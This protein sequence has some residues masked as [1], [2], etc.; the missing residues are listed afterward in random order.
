MFS[1]PGSTEP[2]TELIYFLLSFQLTR[3]KQTEKH[4]EVIALELFGGVYNFRLFIFGGL[5]AQLREF[6]II[7]S[8]AR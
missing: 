1:Q 4:F 6:K 5:S 8:N 3:H 2:S 7:Y